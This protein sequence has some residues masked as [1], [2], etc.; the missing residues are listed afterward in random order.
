MQLKNASIINT[1]FCECIA[2]GSW[3]M[4]REVVLNKINF[5]KK[6]NAQKIMHRISFKNCIKTLYE[7]IKLYIACT[8]LKVQLG[9]K[10]KT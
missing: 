9:A 2:V 10:R 5:I 7:N 3:T 6:K 4:K 1:Y 8:S